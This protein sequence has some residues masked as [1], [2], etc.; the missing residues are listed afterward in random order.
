MSSGGT[1]RGRLSGVDDG[2]TLGTAATASL[3][4]TMSV[5]GTPANIAIEASFIHQ[6]MGHG[7]PKAPKLSGGANGEFAIAD[8]VPS[9]AGTWELQLELTGAT[10][11]E[12]LA[13]ELE[14]TP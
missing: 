6:G 10:G 13:F 1:Y 9:M 12:T 8:L 7:G 11:T 5:D 14:V 4:V 3:V 2:V